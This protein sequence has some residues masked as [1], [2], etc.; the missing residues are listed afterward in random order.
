MSFDPN[1]GSSFPPSTPPVAPKKSNVLLYVLLGI[2]GVA[3]LVCCGCAG[4][5]YFGGSSIMNAALTAAAEEVRPSLA[6]DPVVQEH[7]GEIESVTVN[8]SSMMA[9]AQANQKAGNAEQRMVIDIKGSKANGQAVGVMD[10]GPPPKLRNGELR[11]NGQTYPL[12]P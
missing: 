12:T 11:V 3:L 7:I 10:A 8:F 9:E 5:M 2:G 6:A 1:S 4:T